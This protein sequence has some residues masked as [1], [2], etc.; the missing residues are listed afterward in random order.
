MSMFYTDG[1][2]DGFLRRWFWRKMFAFWTRI[3]DRFG[4]HDLRMRE[5]LQ[6]SRDEAELFRSDDEA[7]LTALLFTLEVIENEGS[8][9]SLGAQRHWRA[10]AAARY[11]RHQVD[12]IRSLP[13]QDRKAAAP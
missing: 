8:S 13:R 2:H 5:F 4:D 11:H 3:M 7:I 6:Q 9:A 1:W 12:W 10:V